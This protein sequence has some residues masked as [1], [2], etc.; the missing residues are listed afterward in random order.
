MMISIIIPAYNEEG[1]VLPIYNKIS[2]ILSPINCAYEII[3]VND[4]STDKTE[5]SILQIIEND[6]NVKLISFSRNFGHMAALIAGYQYCDGDAAI[7]MD[8][9][10]Q[11]PPELIIELLKGWK[12][13]F[14][15]VN[16]IRID[17]N[18]KSIF[19][20]ITSKYYYVLFSWFCDFPLESGS[21]DYR[22]VSRKVIDKLNSLEEYEIFLRGMVHWLGFNS[23]SITYIANPRYSGKTKYNL[24]KMLHFAIHGIT[25]FSIKPLKLITIIGFFVSGLTFVYMIFTIYYAIFLKE[26]V[27]G[28][29]SLILSILFLGGVQL[30]SIGV[31]GEYIG[32]IFIETKK[33]PRFIINYRK[34]V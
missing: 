26:A 15:I 22:L 31:L 23:T 29:T 1:N 27:S 11:H 3:F 16:T 24:R 33:R 13:N 20:K 10:L 25:S 7:T 5:K 30:I 17:A 14:E 21:A 19:K 9:D 12:N 2:E 8:C 4:G 28:W 32:K 6:K 18:E 34:G